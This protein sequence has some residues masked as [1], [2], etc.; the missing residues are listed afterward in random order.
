[1]A[2][3]NGQLNMM[4]L[5]T[6]QE[7]DELTGLIEDVPVYAPEFAQ[8]PVETR[9]GTTYKLVQ[10]VALPAA[11]FR[12]VNQ[13]QGTQKSVYKQTVKEMFPIDVYLAVDRIIIQADDE[14]AGGDLLTKEAQ[15]A[16]Q[17]AILTIG[18]QFYYGTGNDPLG[19]QGLRQQMTNNLA[20]GGTTNTTT[21]YLVW[22]HPW[23]VKFTVGRKGQIGLDPWNLFPFIAPVPGTTGASYIMAY[24]T[25]L[26]C[27][28]GLT[29]GSNYSVY[30]VTGLSGPGVTTYTLTDRLGIQLVSYVPLTRRQGLMWFMNRNAHAQLVQSRM[31]VN[32]SGAYNGGLPFSTQKIESGAD[33]GVYPD[34]GMLAG[35]PICV[36]DSV[37]NTETNG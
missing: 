19:F 13:G 36:T 5:I 27:W 1:M 20:A 21:A 9:E 14:S 23:G 15:G 25:N 2:T 6:N 32:V 33:A 7:N 30:G 35:Y 8:V 24:Q 28:I 37:S 31:T 29:V 3:F 17:S 11:Q 34:G 12:A 22:L 10:R 16:L 18:A 4:D 26:S